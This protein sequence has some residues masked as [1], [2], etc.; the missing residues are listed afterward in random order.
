M[1]AFQSQE[2][3]DNIASSMQKYTPTT[4]GSRTDLLAQLDQIRRDG[5]AINLGERVVGVCG[6]AAPVTNIAGDVRAAIGISGPAERLNH[7]TLRNYG[8]LVRDIAG[9][10]SHDLGAPSK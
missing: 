7:Y 9:R 4:A 6:V 8:P 5:F 1:L 10:L 3:I 2:F